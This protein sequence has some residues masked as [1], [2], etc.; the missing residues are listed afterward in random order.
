VWIEGNKAKKRTM[1]ERTF[2]RLLFALFLVLP[3]GCSK[4]ST[5]ADTRPTCNVHAD[6]PNS[7]ACYLGHCYGTTTCIERKGC[8][9]VPVCDGPGCVCSMDTNRC[10]PVCATD[11]DCAKDGYCVNGIC[12]VY[13]A[14]FDG[15]PPM[16]SGKSSLSVGVARVE[17]DFPMG[18]SMAGYAARTGPYTPYRGSLGGSNAWLDKPDVR[19]LAFDDGKEMFVLLRLPLGWSTDEIVADTVLKVQQKR[20]INLIDHLITNAPHSHSLPARFWHLARGLSLGYF[21]Y[22]EFQFE[23]FDRMTT[24]YADAVIMA[25]DAMQPAKFGYTVVDNF[26][27]M[28]Q[29][30]RDRRCEDDGLKNWLQLDDRMILMRI[31]DM[32]GAPM[33]VLTHFGMHGTVFDSDNPI[34][35]ED[36]PGGVEMILTHR[37][38]E[39]Y[40]RPVL[41]MY[42]QGNAGNISPSGDDLGHTAAERLQLIGE[43]T[44]SVIAPNLDRITTNANLEIG[45]VS[46]YIPITHDGLGYKPT[47]F[48]DTNAVRCDGDVPFFRYGAFQ[49]VAPSHNDP[50]MPYV[51]GNLDCVFSVECLGDGY[52]IP[53]FQKTHLAVVRIGDL[54]FA[55]MPGEPV[56]ELGRRLGDRLKET[57]PGINTTFTL[58]YSMDHH[59]YLLDDL[60]WLQGGYEPSR[61]I[62]GWKMGGYFV[63]KSLALASQLA[64]A[65]ADRLIDNGNLKPMVWDD[66]PAANKTVAPN[67]TEGAPD[68]VLIDAGAKVERLDLVTF[69]WR[70]GHPG[71]DRPHVVLEMQ[72]QDGSF[73]AVKRPGGLLYD[74][75]GFNF[76]VHYD[77]M[78]TSDNCTLHKWRVVWE[79]TRD[80]PLGHYR[81]RADGRAWKGGAPIDYT[82]KSSAFEIVPST[83]LQVY[84]LKLNGTQIEGRIV[85]PRAVVFNK[86]GDKMVADEAAGFFMRSPLVPDFLG[87]PLADGTQLTTSGTIRHAQAMASPISGAVAASMIV[88]N[89]DRVVG[90]AADGTPQIQSAGMRPT[91]KFLLD[92]SAIASGSAGNYLVTV[93]LTD[94]LGNSGTVTATI[95]K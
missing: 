14:K 49:C 9:K 83:K 44:W 76:M 37:A 71:V 39:K 80:F 77:G 64:K 56:S 55:T 19:A 61:D 7:G 29:I 47:E 46:Q 17:L 34:L 1:L 2:A 28:G 8:E 35:T 95:T 51:D 3:T 6:C 31:D 78:C 67:E 36:A 43:R 5:P 12:T 85:D 81:I 23:V 42:L 60:D 32:N 93:Q 26:D 59:F 53:Q 72:Q 87:A 82:A 40:G 63:D 90:Y 15:M 91:S 4:K 33:A 69:Q 62:W 66:P 50:T 48:Y 58:G 24:S 73:A 84:G 54:A 10:Y 13:P 25:I 11:N 68:E 52:P 65:P 22:D 57:I 92:G 41:G 70:G 21:G 86:D 45:V 30:H 16:P 20:G 18:V 88:E 27:P 75:S 74:D 94:P 38:S 79:E 89:R